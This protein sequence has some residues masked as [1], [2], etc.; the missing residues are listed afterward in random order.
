MTVVATKSEKWIVDTVKEMAKQFEFT[1]KGRFEFVTVE[2]KAALFFSHCFS[3]IVLQKWSNDD[4]VKLSE[5][6]RG[7]YV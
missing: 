5:C 1:N 4:L 2:V 7:W 6:V 3:A